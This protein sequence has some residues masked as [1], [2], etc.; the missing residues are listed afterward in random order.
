MRTVA[1]QEAQATFL[2]LLAEVG[3]GESI[4]ITE[5]GRLSSR[6]G[7]TLKK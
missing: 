5:D 6:P 2:A 7:A 1:S 4:T 3:T